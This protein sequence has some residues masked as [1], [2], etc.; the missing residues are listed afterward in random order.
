M[1]GVTKERQG[2]SV[3]GNLILSLKGISKTFDV[4]SNK[5]RVLNAV[6][7]DVREHEF[8]AVMGP[9]GAGK[10]TLLNIMGGLEIPDEGEIFS[11]IR[12]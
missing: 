1:F 10:T 7:L 2:D 3:Q 9:S 8:L 11:R 12:K 6:S 5:Q 4:G